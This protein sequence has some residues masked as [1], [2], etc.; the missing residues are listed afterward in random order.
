MGKKKDS[1]TS[2]DVNKVL[3]LTPFSKMKMVGS[4]SFELVT[5]AV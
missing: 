3:D 2:L 1:A 4:T 5:P